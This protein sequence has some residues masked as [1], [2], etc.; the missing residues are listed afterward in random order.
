MIL[1]AVS[2]YRIDGQFLYVAQDLYVKQYIKLKL[3]QDTE[4]KELEN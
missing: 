4:V 1:D 2:L 3:A